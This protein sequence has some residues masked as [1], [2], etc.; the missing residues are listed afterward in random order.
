MHGSSETRKKILIISDI[1]IDNGFGKEHFVFSLSKELSVKYEV[2]LFE[3]T[4]GEPKK[5]YNEQLQRLGVKLYYYNNWIPPFFPYSVL[6]TR[7]LIELLQI[8]EIVYLAES[9]PFIDLLIILL[10]KKYNFKVFRGY[11]NPLEYDLLPNGQKIS[12]ISIRRL[13]YKFILWIEKRFD[14]IHV[15]NTDHEK[16]LRDLGY[17]KIIIVH[18]YVLSDYSQNG[19]P[20]FEDFSVIFL[21]RLNYHKGS[22]LIPSIV[23]SLEQKGINFVAYVVG[24]GILGPEIEEYCSKKD[25]CNYLG[26]ISNQD[27]FELLSK[28]HVLIAPTRVEAFM[29]TGVE[30]MALGTPV[31]SFPVPGPN[32]YIQNGKNGYVVKNVSELSEKVELIFEELR[33]GIYDNYVVNCLKTASDYTI[34]SGKGKYLELMQKLLD[35]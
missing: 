10:K 24:E 25:N 28:C 35:K 15:E 14:G 2:H 34:D 33:N 20:K 17:S 12:K 1:N 6:S 8:V 30:A 19:R 29:L 13:Y 11:H 16:L 22:D 26:F 32:D 18:P 4:F 21:G 5:D 7:K 23:D 9:N 31:I 27:K 3:S